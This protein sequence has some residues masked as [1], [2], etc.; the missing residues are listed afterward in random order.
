MVTHTFDFLEVPG[1]IG[2]R[3]LP[4]ARNTLTVNYTAAHPNLGNV[5]IGMKGPGG[6]YSLAIT[7]N[8]TA[9]ADNQFG[10]AT[11][12]PPPT[13]ADLAPWAYMV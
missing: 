3:I 13:V 11:L 5:S 8:G 1:N 2:L 4:L 9:T 6:P 12:S 7:P 10:T